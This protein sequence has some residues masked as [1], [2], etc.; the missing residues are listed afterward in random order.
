MRAGRGGPPFL[1]NIAGGVLGDHFL[2]HRGQ[3]G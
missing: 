2:R 3:V 1:A